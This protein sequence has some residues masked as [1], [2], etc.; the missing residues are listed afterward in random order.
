LQKIDKS[1]K[2]FKISINDFE[3]NILSDNHIY[4]FISVKF[5]NSIFENKNNFNYFYDKSKV[6][7]LKKNNKIR[8]QGLQITSTNKNKIILQLDNFS[9]DTYE[10]F[11]YFQNIK[12]GKILNDLYLEM[13]LLEITLTIQEIEKIIDILSI[14][15]NGVNKLNVEDKKNKNGVSDSKDINKTEIDNE[16]ENHENEVHNFIK[17]HK[18]NF[19]L[20]DKYLLT[21]FS[22]FSFVLSLEE[23]KFLFSKLDIAIT[24]INIKIMNNKSSL[25]NA[26]LISRN[27]KIKLF[28]EFTINFHKMEIL[29]E[30]GFFSLH[31]ECLLEM[32]KFA[33]KL[34]NII[35]KLNSNENQTKESNKND[36]VMIKEND[37]EL[38]PSYSKK[39][40]KSSQKITINEFFIFFF[41]DIEN[42][43]ILRIPKIILKFGEELIIEKINFYFRNLNYLIVSNQ[44]NHSNELNPIQDLIHAIKIIKLEGFKFILPTNN[45]CLES[46]ISNKKKKKIH[47]LKKKSLYSVNL[48]EMSIENIEI[49]FLT[50]QLLIPFLKLSKFFQFFPYWIEHYFNHTKNKDNKNTI[51][52]VDQNNLISGDKISYN[53]NIK[54]FDKINEKNIFKFKINK[55]SCNF[56]EDLASYKKK[57]KINNYSGYSIAIINFNL[58]LYSYSEDILKLDR[59]GIFI[60][61]DSY[62]YIIFLLNTFIAIK[63]IIKM[64]IRKYI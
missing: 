22:D 39:I 31:D 20:E 33:G 55:A 9:F 64:K 44:S 18:I 29:I 15:L 49:N 1:L 63:I 24:P 43:F 38:K 30:R 13:P 61:F 35:S 4:K 51:V 54:G 25:Y 48:T 28:Q 17:I 21:E 12:N 37:L 34:H 5:S 58:N 6:R 47:Y 3:L 16:V 42:L 62:N 56:N 60:F 14:I 27:I 19:I 8:I 36:E 45:I 40:V 11:T 10:D 7:L 52:C 26:N 59:D 53:S 50:N 46:K 57:D 23:K 41:S 2:K 32:V